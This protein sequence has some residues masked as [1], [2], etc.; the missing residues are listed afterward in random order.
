MAQPYRLDVPAAQVS[1]RLP[2]A[3]ALPLRQR[4]PHL[5]A[6]PQHGPHR[7]EESAQEITAN[8]AR[9]IHDSGGVGEVPDSQVKGLGEGGRRARGGQGRRVDVVGDVDERVRE[10][11]ADIFRSPGVL[12]HKVRLGVVGGDCDRRRR[13]RRS[14]GCS[15]QRGRGGSDSEGGSVGAR[16]GGGEG[17][18]AVADDEDSA[19]G[20]EG[21]EVEPHERRGL[22]HPQAQPPV[23][24]ALEEGPPQSEAGADGQGGLGLRGAPGGGAVDR[25]AD[26]L[27][28]VVLHNGVGAPGEEGGQDDGEA[29]EA[30][31]GEAARAVE[32]LERDER[33]V[34]ERR[35]P[36]GRAER[37]AL[38]RLADVHLRLLL[39]NPLGGL[40]VPRVHFRVW[41][42]ARD[43]RDEGRTVAS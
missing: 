8:G 7:S 11:L 39:R 43:A 35:Q 24:P 36:G 13:R 17:Q 34:V 32:L 2:R 31:R 18:V 30:D 14:S 6:G 1:G 19:A 28:R 25:D 5:P 38:G 26:A 21:E 9:C 20:R 27:A 3:P 22:V 42:E 16:E 23:Q 41:G 40:G 12:G 33:Q 15:A 37:G 4:D 29:E 10:Q